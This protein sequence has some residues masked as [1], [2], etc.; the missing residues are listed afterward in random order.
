MGSVLIYFYISR[1][2]KDEAIKEIKQLKEL[3]DSGILTQ[4]EYDSK[5]AD[6]KKIILDS[7][8]KKDETSES[9]KEY[10][11]QKAKEKSKTESRLK[12]T[13]A[14]QEKETVKPKVDAAQNYIEK[15]KVIKISLKQSVI[16]SSIICYIISYITMTT[17]SPDSYN[18]VEAFGAFL[19][20]SIPAIIYLLVKKN[21]VKSKYTFFILQNV[22]VII[23]GFSNYT[24]LSNMGSSSSRP[25]KAIE[26]QAPKHHSPNIEQKGSRG[27]HIIKDSKQKNPVNSFPI[28]GRK[29]FEFN[30]SDLT[31]YLWKCEMDDYLY[32]YPDVNSKYRLIEIKEGELVRIVKGTIAFEFWVKVY[33]KNKVGYINKSFFNTNAIEKPL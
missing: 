13:E 9:K 2:N 27:E 32:S 8:K 3:L 7:S 31:N 21:K 11:E 16:I 22:L 5:S 29:E 23:V 30:K 10:W 20:S 33:F 15:E 18:G 26:S 25:T 4:E 24:A 12:Q 14:K 1:M 17:D 19:F 6:L 28:E